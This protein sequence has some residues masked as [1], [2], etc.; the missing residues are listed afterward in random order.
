M[1]TLVVPSRENESEVCPVQLPAIRQGHDALLV[2]GD[3]VDV[4][5]LHRGQRACAQLMREGV[6][7]AGER[8]WKAAPYGGAG[9]SQGGCNIY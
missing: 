8:V 6:S 9:E 7:E 4:Q 2:V 3:V 5:V 1:T